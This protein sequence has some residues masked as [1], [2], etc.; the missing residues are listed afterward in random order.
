MTLENHRLGQRT[1]H[2]KHFS[3]PKWS[4]QVATGSDPGIE[5]HLAFEPAKPTETQRRRSSSPRPHLLSRVG[6]W[7]LTPRRAR[8][9]V[10]VRLSIRAIT[11]TNISGRC[12]TTLK[13]SE[14]NP[15]V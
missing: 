15:P 6:P 5:S 4:C 7:G 2:L 9:R 11:H 12:P 3:R 14:E 13:P 8:S 1:G 10:S